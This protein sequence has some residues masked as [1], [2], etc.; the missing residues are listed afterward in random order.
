MKGPH[1]KALVCCSTLDNKET[2]RITQHAKPESWMV[3]QHNPRSHRGLPRFL[4]LRLLK[5]RLGS[6]IVSRSKEGAQI[7]DRH[8][9]K[10]WEKLCTNGK[11][12]PDWQIPFSV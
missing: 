5:A 9:F 1:C 12:I 3:W 2:W 6:S 8:I 11:T 7:R 4:P 10:P